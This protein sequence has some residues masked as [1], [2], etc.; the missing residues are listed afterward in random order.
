MNII[1]TGS[2]GFLAKK[3]IS[4][5]S[6]KKN[7]II[8]IDNKLNDIK[9]KKNF[10]F[11]KCDITNNKKLLKEIKK[12]K[13]KID[14]VIHMAAL[15][16]LSQKQDLFKMN[17]VNSLGTSN[18]LSICK[19][20]SIK[21]LIYTSSF[22]VYGKKNKLPIKED[23]IL[24]PQNYYGISKIFAEK[25]IQFYASKNNLKYI[26][27]RFD[28]IY[29][30]NQNMPGF[31][32]MCYENMIKNKNIEIFNLGKQIRDQVYVDDAASSIIL[33]IK[34]ISSINSEIFNVAGGMPITNYLL[35]KILLKQLKSKSK[36]IKINKTN[37][38]LSNSYLNLTKIKKI[39]GYKPKTIDQNIKLYIKEM[40]SNEK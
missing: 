30:N 8:G 21:K 4:N 12:I 9:I 28:G 1:I 22:S 24:N 37:P 13:L 16:P 5:I 27:L 36:I 29:G 19:E 33:S 20:L 32:K 39:L 3:L 14:L 2:N 31:I 25:Q 18:I 7:F 11:I 26:I 34:K 40:G 6:K 38:N 35:A 23:V 10:K 15:Q 17:S